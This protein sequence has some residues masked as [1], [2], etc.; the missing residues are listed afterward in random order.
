MN[1]TQNLRF[2]RNL[3]LQ[4][5][6]ESFFSISRFVISLVYANFVA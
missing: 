3:S 1:D 5:P 2:F 4:V 6:E